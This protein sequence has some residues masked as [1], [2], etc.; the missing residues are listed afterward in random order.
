MTAALS[1]R[2]VAAGIDRVHVV[3]EETGPGWTTATALANDAPE[4]AAALGRIR[5]WSG[6]PSATV[7][8][9][10]FF[11]SY[12]WCLG[13]GAAAALLIDDRLPDLDPDSVKLR[14]GA[15]GRANG[16]SFAGG[17]VAGTNGLGPY[18]DMLVAHLEPLVERLHRRCRHSR[19]AFWRAAGD[20]AAF[21]LAWCGRALSVEERG[22]ALGRALLAEPSPLGPP[23]AFL[24]AGRLVCQRH[25]C[26]LW[27]RTPS[28]KRCVGCPVGRA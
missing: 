18:R 9:A 21:T 23:R 3:A 15:N 13:G 5:A 28:A 8:G 11:D 6:A 27:L 24:T 22:L 7:S 12:V 17:V 1:E 20:M 26:C 4:L 14:F 25:G 2:I 16:L 10:L 19:A